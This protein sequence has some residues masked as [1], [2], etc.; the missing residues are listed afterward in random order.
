M[1]KNVFNNFD[2]TGHPSTKGNVIIGN[3]VW[4]AENATIISGVTIGDGA[5]IANNSHVVK[6]VE[7]YSIVGGNPAKLIKYRFTKDQIDKLLSIKWWYWTDN[8]INENIHLLCNN[9]IDNFISL[10]HINN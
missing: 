3:D 6:N 10:H 4:I 7:P 5:V 1:N 9:N 8:K 2:G